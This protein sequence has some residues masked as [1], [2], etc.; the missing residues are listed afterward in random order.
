MYL[1]IDNGIGDN[2]VT[3]LSNNFKYIPNLIELDISSIIY[4]I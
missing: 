4:F 2:G 1:Y 3:E